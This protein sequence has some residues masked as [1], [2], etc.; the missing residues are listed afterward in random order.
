MNINIQE[1]MR[2]Y[3]EEQLKKYRMSI[4]ELKK[5]LRKERLKHS[6]YIFGKKIS[7]VEDDDGVGNVFLYKNEIEVLKEYVNSKKISSEINSSYREDIY[8]QINNIDHEMVTV[9]N[10]KKKKIQQSNRII[11]S[12]INVIDIEKRLVNVK[13]DNLTL[14][15]EYYISKI[16]ATSMAE[17]RNIKVTAFGGKLSAARRELR[18]AM[19]DII[20]KNEKN[21]KTILIKRDPLEDMKKDRMRKAAIYVRKRMNMIHH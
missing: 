19:K 2:D 16:P 5:T 8:M 9:K 11:N 20:V 13:E 4:K 1:S 7:D 14:L 10:K 3:K 21:E 12:I 18:N 17:K 6:N 15:F